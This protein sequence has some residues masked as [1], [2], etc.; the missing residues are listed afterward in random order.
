[1]NKKERPVNY[2]PQLDA[3]RAFAVLL[4][5][6]SHWFNEEHFLNR[7]SQNGS[8]GVTLFFGLS[9]FLITGILLRNKKQVEGGNSTSRACKIFYARRALRIFPVYFLLL[10]ILLA[11]NIASIRESFSWHFFYGSDFFFW[12]KGTFEDLLSH[13]W[14]LAV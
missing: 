14:F 3:L 5:I 8:L 2:M 6:I 7:Y 11:F 13:L 12:L 10:F 4:V 1:M 9:G